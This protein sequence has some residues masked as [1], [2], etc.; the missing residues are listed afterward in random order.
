MTGISKGRSLELFFIDGKPDGMLTAT[1]PFQWTGHVLMTSRNQIAD[2]LGRR[3]AKRTGV[4]LLIGE[5]D[6]VPTIY[7]GETEDISVR[8]KTHDTQRDWWS[9]AILITSSDDDLNKAHVRYLES[10]LIE[11]A[12]DIGKI[13]LENTKQP[14]VPKLSESA[15]A[16]M[17]GF[18]E[19]IYMVLP[20]IG[21]DVFLKRTRPT[22]TESAAINQVAAPR[23]ELKVKKTGVQASAELLDGD[24][25][26]HEGSIARMKWEGK[27][28]VNSTYGRLFEELIQQGILVKQGEHRVFSQNYAFSNTSAA[29]AVVNGRPSPGPNEWKLQGTQKSYKD[30]EEER[31]AKTLPNLTLDDLG[32]SKDEE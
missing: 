10:R 30:W 18:L 12:K 17:E 23:F 2:A 19:N 16:N 29:G 28:S 4:Y 25:V 21:I 5:V 32:I 7:I 6:G 9:T 20:A 1:V 27:N 8:I 15:E 22:R 26:V 13:K 14:N 31:L 24:F 3:E 11:T